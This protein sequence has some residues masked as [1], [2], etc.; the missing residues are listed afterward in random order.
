[1]NALLR[2]SACTNLRNALTS[3]CLGLVMVCWLPSAQAASS[4]VVVL[5]DDSGSMNDRMRNGNQKQPRMEVAKTALRRVIEQ[6]PESTQLGV[7]LLNGSSK[8]D[9]WLIPLGPLDRGSA[10]SRID[11]LRA[12]GG[13]PLGRAMKVAVDELQELRRQQPYGDYRLLVVTDGEASD[14]GVLQRNLPEIISRG[15]V[16]D[17][18]GVDMKSD[19]SLAQLSHSYRRANDA[20]S[21]ERAVSEIFAE[22][23]S[24]DDS[25]AGQ[26]DFD[27]LAGLPDDFAQE[28][29]RALSQLQTQYLQPSPEDVSQAVGDQT[30]RTGNVPKPQDL[31]GGNSTFFG[32]RWS[33]LLFF[34]FLLVMIQWTV[35]WLSKRN[36]R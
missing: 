7:L 10:I 14:R 25:I 5:L 31:D 18:I 9:G 17:V 32:L 22:S 11:Q 1:M 33:F 27:L 19:H 20:A 30:R 3:L 13:T 12:R 24:L 35:G 4:I 6:L 29:L 8:T 34:F 2:G 36:K 28:S 15:I 23:A 16:I 21:F 26:S